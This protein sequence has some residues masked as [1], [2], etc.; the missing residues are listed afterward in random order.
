MR[1][2]YSFNSRQDSACILVPISLFIPSLPMRKLVFFYYFLD[3]VVLDLDEK[4]HECSSVK[5][6]IDAD[7]TS[8]HHHY[9]FQHLVCGV[10]LY[11]M[12][13]KE[14]E[15][16]AKEQ[17]W[18]VC[19]VKI[20]QTTPVV[21]YFQNQG[22]FPAIL[23]CVVFNNIQ[24]VFWFPHK[25]LLKSMSFFRLALCILHLKQWLLF[26][27]DMESEIFEKIEIPKSIMSLWIKP[28]FA[29]KQKAKFLLNPWMLHVKP[30]VAVRCLQL[31]EQLCSDDFVAW[32]STFHPTGTCFALVKVMP[33]ATLL[34]EFQSA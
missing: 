3:I 27:K 18:E 2:I 4:I 15:A 19:S 32:I 34:H 14:D 31:S 9:P 28:T 21:W 33:H 24:E 22:T 20:Y 25:K 29:I 1:D 30:T 5:T 13:C 23:V 26:Q 10:N 17:S 6:A 12:Q 7:C 11:R 8:L 16:L